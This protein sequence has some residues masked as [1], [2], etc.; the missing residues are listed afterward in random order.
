MEF[1]S[2]ARKGLKSF[3]QGLAASFRKPPTTSPS[4]TVETIM[5]DVARTIHEQR[6]TRLEKIMAALQ[7]GRKLRLD[8]RRF[9]KR[10]LARQAAARG[11]ELVTM[12]RSKRRYVIDKRGAWRRIVEP[13]EEHQA[14]RGVI[15]RDGKW[16]EVG[17]STPTTAIP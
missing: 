3:L 10:T 9:L 5:E 6:N 1:I 8:D 7:Q 17:S 15:R 11:G 13:H 12:D 16:F 2:N 4:G 14:K